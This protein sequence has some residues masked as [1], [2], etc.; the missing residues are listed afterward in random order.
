MRD[1]RHRA[2]AVLM[3][4]AGIAAPLAAAQ[5]YPQ[6]PLRFIVP[7]APGGGLDITARLQ[8]DIARAAR[9]PEAGNLFA[10]DGSTVIASTPAVFKAALDAEHKKWGAVVRT[11]GIKTQ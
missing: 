6:R 1:A 10:A 7:F 3:A 8:R 5:E 4:F 2:R 9:T 11:A